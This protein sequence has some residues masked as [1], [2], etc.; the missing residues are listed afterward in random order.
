VSEYTSRFWY[1]GRY[2]L[3][4]YCRPGAYVSLGVH[5][6]TDLELHF[7][8][9]IVILTSAVKGR[10]LEEADAYYLEGSEP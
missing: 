6:G 5:I 4:V 7:L 1:F 9:W 10:E 8:W 2:C 3:N